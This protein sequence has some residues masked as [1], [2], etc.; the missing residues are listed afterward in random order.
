MRAKINIWIQNGKGEKP[1][2]QLREIQKRR[3]LLVLETIKKTCFVFPKMH[4]ENQEVIGEEYI[5]GG[6]GDLS[7]DDAAK[8]LTWI[9]HVCRILSFSG[10]R[11]FHMLILLLVQ[12]SS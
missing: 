11:I 9:L 10:L 12:H 3:S 4:T 1:S 6:D 2:T 5:Q 8:K 7:L